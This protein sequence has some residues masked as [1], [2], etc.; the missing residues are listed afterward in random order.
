MTVE[1]KRQLWEQMQHLLENEVP[2]PRTRYLGDFK[3]QQQVLTRLHSVI[4]R[5]E[6]PIDATAAALL[7]RL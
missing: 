6:A 5:R 1:M 2:K 4:R 3:A 7:E